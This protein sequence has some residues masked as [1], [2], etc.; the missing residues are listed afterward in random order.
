MGREGEG[1]Y[2]PPGMPSPVHFSNG[3]PH[4][5]LLASPA[6]ARV[7]K[8]GLCKIKEVPPPTTAILWP[9]I[10]TTPWTVSAA[11]GSAPDDLRAAARPSP[12]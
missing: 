12:Q 8:P 5:D 6:S 3:T 11:P 2:A 9:G 10:P 1:Y 7:F 4:H